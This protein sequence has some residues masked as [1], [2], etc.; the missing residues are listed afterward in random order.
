MDIT[1]DG[2]GFMLVFGDLVW[3]PFI[4]SM[5]CRYLVDHDSAMPTWAL[6]AIF[7]LHTV[8]LIIF[9][10]ANSQKDRFRRNPG[11]YSSCRFLRLACLRDCLPACLPCLPASLRT[12]NDKKKQ[13]L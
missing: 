6:A 11:M 3:V 4:Y 9:R 5:Q 10:G 2:F 12:N 7:V 8:G 1:T 13:S